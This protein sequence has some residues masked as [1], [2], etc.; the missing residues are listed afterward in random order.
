MPKTN[1]LT[2][3]LRFSSV[4]LTVFLAQEVFLWGFQHWTDW[5]PRICFWAAW[6]PAV[7]LHFL[8]TKFFTF[9]SRT[10]AI[11]GQI[12][13][14][15]GATSITTLVQYGIYHFALKTISPQ[16]NIALVIAAALGTTINFVIMKWGVFEPK[17]SP[18][19]VLQ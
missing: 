15:C 7:T 17:S 2:K 4:G 18:V 19:T 3:F 1:L 13:R 9:R 11:G 12:V 8:L 5:G 6:L 14:Y 10:N 16:P